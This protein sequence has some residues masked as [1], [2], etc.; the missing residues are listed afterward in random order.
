MKKTCIIAVLALALCAAAYHATR[1]KDAAL[2][3][4]SALGNI[5]VIAREEGSGTKDAFK[6]LVV[7]DERGA[8]AIA[9]ST[10][11]AIE[12]TAADVNA[13]AYVAYGSLAGANGV[14][15]LAVDGVLPDGKSIA[16]GKYP[17]VR[18][19]LLAYKGEL[20]EL[21]ADFLT[22]V[23]GAGQAIVADFCT[24]IG[25]PT[26]FLSLK[27]AGRLTICGSSSAAPLVRRLAEG[28][29]ALNRSA[30]ITV[31]ASDS[32]AGINS[33]LRGDCDLAMSSR[34]LKDY[35]A[36]LLQTAKIAVDGVAV[37]VGDGNPLKSL[38]VRRIRAIYDGSAASWAK[39]D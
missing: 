20:G 24:P 38:S 32:T 13:I 10:Q 34:A 22:Y 25:K 5:T 37:I 19:Y 2:P 16:S 30:E 23:R 27:P 26:S 1:G 17:L 7:T 39:L 21:A 8:N 18:P 3:D 11:Q 14:R 28:Y 33:A 36:E 6:A 12:M 9:A 31:E 35:E 15:A 29:C 4:L